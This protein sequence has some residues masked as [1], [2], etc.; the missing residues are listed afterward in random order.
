MVK[1]KEIERSE[2]SKV[3]GEEWKVNI[4]WQRI[5][6]HQTGDF[7]RPDAKVEHSPLY[8]RQIPALS[9]MHLIIYFPVT[10]LLIHISY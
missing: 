7:N 5:K 8:I 4:P 3:N 6:G 9:Y 1:Y 2:G 10:N